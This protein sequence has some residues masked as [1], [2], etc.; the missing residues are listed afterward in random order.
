MHPSHLILQSILEWF[1][2]YWERFWSL[3][4]LL[5]HIY[6]RSIRN[7]EVQSQDKIPTISVIC[8]PVSPKTIIQSPLAVSK[9]G[10]L[11]LIQATVF[12][13]GRFWRPAFDLVHTRQS[14]FLCLPLSQLYHFG[15][16]IALLSANYSLNISSNT[17]IILSFPCSI[18]TWFFTIVNRDQFLYTN[19]EHYYIGKNSQR[20]LDRSV[21][22]TILSISA[23]SCI[24]HL[25][26]LWVLTL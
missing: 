19:Y 13:C 24:R 21:I 6:H 8:T 26:D 3:V 11:N 1:I 25:D 15:W 14:P 16:L 7:H 20:H 2:R 5:H 9:M 18:L 4:L 10:N 22:P 12:W 23:P 17:A